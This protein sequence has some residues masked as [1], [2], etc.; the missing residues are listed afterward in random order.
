MII[1]NICIPVLCMKVDLALEGLNI[2]K[3]FLLKSS[4]V[5][6]LEIELDLL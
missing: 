5:F 6:D 3:H 4:L 1:Q 2:D